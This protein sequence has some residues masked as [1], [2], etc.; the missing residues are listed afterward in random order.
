[1]VDH[2]QQTSRLSRRVPRVRAQARVARYDDEDVDRLLANAGI[3]RNRRKIVAAIE[4]ARAFLQVQEEFGSFD[5]YLWAFVGGEPLRHR[6][7]ALSELP[8]KS[9]ES[10]TLSKDLIKRGFRFVGPTICYAF[11][12]SAGLINDHLVSCFRYAQV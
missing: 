3:V 6:F 5:S 12:Q 4:N 2:P 1:M 8:A 11:M 9:A 7:A 10:E